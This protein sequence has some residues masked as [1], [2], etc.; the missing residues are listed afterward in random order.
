MKCILKKL[1]GDW[2]DLAPRC[3]QVAICCERS[4]EPPSPIKFEGLLG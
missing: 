3:G 1:D 2:F 4:D